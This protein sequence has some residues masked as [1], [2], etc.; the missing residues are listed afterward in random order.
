M[1][2]LVTTNT[3]R[4]IGACLQCHSHRTDQYRNSNHNRSLLPEVVAVE[5]GDAVG[6]ALPELLPVNIG[7]G[8]LDIVPVTEGVLEGLTVTESERGKPGTMHLH[9]CVF[10]GWIAQTRCALASHC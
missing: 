10:L 8:L 3:H 9:C 4:C 1:E 6:V 7:E 2:A 5:V